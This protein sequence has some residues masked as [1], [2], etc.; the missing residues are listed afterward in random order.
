MEAEQDAGG[1]FR[2]A[3]QVAS[4]PREAAADFRS[5]FSVSI[6]EVTGP[7]LLD[8]LDDLLTLPE[9]RLRAVLAGWTYPLTRTDLH[10][11]N[12][13]DYL[14]MRWLRDKYKPQ[15]RPWDKAPK[16]RKKRH[17]AEE[18]MRILRPHLTGQDPPA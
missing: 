10:L 2:L 17:T 16:T 13:T 18:A 7:E 9:S 14:L 4:Y 1:I 3:K 6:R 8:L 11:L 5:I 15:P 12:L